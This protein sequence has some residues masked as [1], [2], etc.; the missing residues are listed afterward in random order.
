MFILK[1][2]DEIELRLYD[3]YKVKD[4]YATI[5]RNRAHIGRF[6]DWPDDHQDVEDTRAFVRHARR[7][8]GRGET[9]DV[10]IFYK[11]EFVGSVALMNQSTSVKKAEIGYW[12]A[13]A[14]TGRG[15]IT[16]AARAMLSYAFDVLNMHKV[17]LRCGTENTK[18]CAVAQR[19][20]FTL[21]GVDVHAEVRYGAY[22]DFN[23]YRL[24]VDDWDVDFNDAEF[25]LHIGADLELRPLQK[26]HIGE[27]FKVSYAN[28]RHLGRWLPWAHEGMTRDDTAAFIQSA[29][30]QYV[31]NDGVQMGIWHEGVLCG[32]IGY[33]YWDFNNR[34]AE[35]GYWLAEDSTGQ[36][37][38]TRSVAHLVE[39]A[40]TVLDLHRIEIMCAA[41]NTASAAI[42][43]R[44]GFTHEGRHRGKA[45][46]RGTYHDL[47]IFAI[48]QPDWEGSDVHLS[49][50]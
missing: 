22:I 17:I 47:D 16:R 41:G 29:L 7:A 14:Y 8:Y 3:D 28:R 48:L 40:F 12:L 31:D 9:I 34:K 15:I 44:L 37:I 33:H 39:Y 45:L 5:D 1:V 38:M 13:Q 42:P 21:D 18:S 4:V 25:A 49:R 36:G 50:R 6:M 19:L 46:L 2:D 20:G 43:K 10:M 32:C 35:I 27:V 30:D 26:R 11:G 23:L 24:L